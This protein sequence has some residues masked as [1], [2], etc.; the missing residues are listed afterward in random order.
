MSV[1]SQFFG[2]SKLIP[3]EIFAVG[4]GG[5]GN[6]ANPSGPFGG[7][8]GGAGLVIYKS[9]HYAV[10]GISY[11]ISI[12]AGGAAGSG[13]PAAAPNGGDTI[14]GG[15]VVAY[16]GGGGSGGLPP[17]YTVTNPT[18]NVYNSINNNQGSL[19]GSVVTTTNEPLFTPFY[20][21]SFVTEGGFAC[22]NIGGTSPPNPSPGITPSG[23]GGGGASSRGGAAGGSPPASFVGGIGGSG[24]WA[25]FIGLTTSYAG[26]GGGGGAGPGGQQG[27]GVDGGG[28]GGGFWPTIGA[29]SAATAGAANKG[30]GGGGGSG[31]GT[32]FPAGAAGGSG[33]LFIRYPT[34]FAAA[35][36]TGNA[37][38]TA[39][40]GY[41]VYGWT[42]GPG[43]ITFS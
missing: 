11:P 25:T 30:G 22:R 23:G 42:S 36:V 15:I 40:P 19:G 10:A 27:V 43:T 32:G 28:T 18:G 13:T 41:N 9:S 8:G 6:A 38:V 14:F 37:P 2:G 7:G 35:T 17:I 33:Y 29:V 24:I 21:P 39:Q 26:G 20:N 12:G 16:G 34:A 3:I 4:G 5:G 31:G 1:L